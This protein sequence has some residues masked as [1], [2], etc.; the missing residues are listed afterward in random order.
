MERED[1]G[2][3]WMSWTEFVHF[4]TNITVCR[5]LPDHVEAR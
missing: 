2:V 5:L 3:F 1:D 4:F